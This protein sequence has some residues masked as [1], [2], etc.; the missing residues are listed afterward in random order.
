MQSEEGVDA[1]A[2]E[3]LDDSFKMQVIDFVFYLFVLNSD[4]G[5]SG[6]GRKKRETFKARSTNIMKLL[7]KRTSPLKINVRRKST[8]HLPYCGESPSALLFSVA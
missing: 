7:L 8:S 5:T 3:G 4:T 6:Y 2:S 1:L